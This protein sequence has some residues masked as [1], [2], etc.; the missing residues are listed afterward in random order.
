MGGGGRCC[1]QF[2]AGVRDTRWDSA[3]IR[4]DSGHPSVRGSGKPGDSGHPRVS[5]HPVQPDWHFLGVRLGRAMH[6]S[7]ARSSGHPPKFRTPKKFG[8]PTEV[9]DTQK[10][11][12]PTQCGWTRSST[13]VRDTHLHPMRPDWHRPILRCVRSGDSG[14]PSDRSSGHPPPPNAAGLASPDIEVCEVRN[15]QAFPMRF[16]A[17]TTTGCASPR[18]KVQ[19]SQYARPGFPGRAAGSSDCA[20]TG[21]AVFDADTPFSAGFPPP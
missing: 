13:E 1:G 7:S 15:T 12:T 19:D 3:G 18:P 10:F 4:R 8:T 14:H 16:G 2:G 9:Q 20:W 5:L 6:R 11:G 17:S 21:A